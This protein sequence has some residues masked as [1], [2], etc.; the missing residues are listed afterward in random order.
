M[1]RLPDGTISFI[2]NIPTTEHAQK[3]WIVRK[4]FEK[5]KLPICTNSLKNFILCKT[6]AELY[7]QVQNCIDNTLYFN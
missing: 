2:R 1:K 4:A 5:I 3:E 7:E 6:K